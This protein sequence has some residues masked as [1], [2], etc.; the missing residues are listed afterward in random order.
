MTSTIDLIDTASERAAREL[1][2]LTG[3]VE[4]MRAVLIRLL[5][6]VVVAERRLSGSEAAQ[7]LEAN[8]QLVVAAVQQIGRAHV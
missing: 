7:L 6:D 5:Q 8:E 2:R 1:T 3:Q 4:A